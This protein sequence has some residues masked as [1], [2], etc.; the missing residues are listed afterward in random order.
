ME[1]EEKAAI[2]QM[3]KMEAWKKAQADKERE[4]EKGIFNKIKLDQ[5]RL[6]AE[7]EESVGSSSV[8]IGQKNKKPEESY[9]SD[10]FEDV[11]VSGSGSKDL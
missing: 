5:A 4:Q 10:P 6:R 9:S 2:E 1:Q 11:S 3:R 8:S 7:Q